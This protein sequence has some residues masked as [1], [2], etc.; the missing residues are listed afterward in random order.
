M[1]AALGLEPYRAAS[2]QPEARLL[3]LPDRDLQALLAP[4]AVDP[5]AVHLP[6]RSSEQ[7]GDALVAV[8][9]VLQGQ[10]P[11]LGDQ[12]VFL[13]IGPG[14]VALGAAGLAQDPAGAAFGDFQLG[15]DMVDAASAPL[16]AQ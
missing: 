2:L 9:G 13:R 16:R 5:F 11:D 7:G 8:A 10:R 14:L 15:P 3:S 12:V 4:D 6:A 1:A